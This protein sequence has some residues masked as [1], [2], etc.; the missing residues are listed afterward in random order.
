[1]VHYDIDSICTCKILQSLLKYKEILYTLSVIRGIEDLKLAYRENCS[2]V[3]YFVLINCGGTVN[4]IDLFEPE[5]DAVF[6][7]IDSHRPTHLDNIYS[8]GQVRLLWTPEE[9]SEVPE[10]HS[11]YRDDVCIP[12][13][14][15]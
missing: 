3:K 13:N 11:V 15:I 10:F 5:E 9:D 14:L 12:L 2:D 4:L 6:F 8:D 1:M 7:I